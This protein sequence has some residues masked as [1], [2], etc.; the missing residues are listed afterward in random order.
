MLQI[1]IKRQFR[2]SNPAQFVASKKITITEG[3]EVVFQIVFP[4]A[5]L[6][7]FIRKTVIDLV[8]AN[9]QDRSHAY[10]DFSFVLEKLNKSFKDLEK[11]YSLEGL[12][13]FFAILLDRELHFSILGDYSV[14][15]V[16]DESITNI[17]DGMAGRTSDFSYISSGTIQRG[18]A[19]FVSNMTL[20]SSLSPDDLYE[21]ARISGHDTAGTIDSL[22][23][24]EM[25]GQ[26]FDLL[27]VYDREVE[28]VPVTSHGEMILGM[29][30]SAY[31]RVRDRL[32]GGEYLA[33]L[34][35]RAVTFIR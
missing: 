29:L 8:L 25:P 5:H 21:I 7:D 26:N 11:Q 33:G 1:D 27:T 24:R 30:G 4:D 3:F 17:A 6:G 9:I 31:S 10:S 34:V 35:S 22:L 18:S 19:A 32:P 15:L 13:I 16:R 23:S 20:L 12:R 2:E 28:Q 14:I